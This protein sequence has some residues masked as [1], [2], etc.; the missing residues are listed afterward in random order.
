[1]PMDMQ[2]RRF[3]K[4]LKAKLTAEQ[5]EQLPYLIG[6]TDKRWRRLLGGVNKTQSNLCEM[7]EDEISAL[8]K[9]LK[10]PESEL[11]EEFGAGMEMEASRLQKFVNSLGKRL[12]I[13]E[14]AA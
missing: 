1:M 6:V 3:E 11:I 5:Y 12:A 8:A 10:V 2:I 14:H 4:Y 9:L 13:V 7:L